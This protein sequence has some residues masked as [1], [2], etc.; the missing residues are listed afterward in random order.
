[1]RILLISY[2]FPP[3][4]IV[5]AVRTGKTAKY[6]WQH[7]HEVRVLTTQRLPF[8]ANL[9]LEI[10]TDAVIRT[11][12]IDTCW[13]SSQVQRMRQQ[14]T[15]VQAVAQHAQTRRMRWLR[16]MMIAYR[17]F[18]AFPDE[19]IGWY[20]FALAAAQRL[21]Q[22]W[23][24]DILL[25]S[26]APPTTLLLAHAL[27]R[28][29]GVPWV[30]EMRDLW[31]D[32][33]YYP[34]PLWRKALDAWLER[35]VLHS[36]AGLVT[37]STP[38]AQT[39]EWRTGKPVGVV[40]NGFDP[41]DYPLQRLPA[42]DGILHIVYTGV[43]YPGHQSAT[44]LFAAL[45]RLGERAGQ[46]RVSFYGNGA[47]Y[48][49]AEAQNQGVERLV[50][51]HGPVPYTDALAQQ[52]AADVVLLLLWNDP[53]EHGVYTGKLFEYLGAR[54]PILAIGPADNVAAALI[55]ERQA[56]IVSSDPAEI[57]AQLTRWLDMKASGADIPDL[58]VS[59]AAGL[60]REEQTRR[61]EQFLERFVGVTSV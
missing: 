48:A 39:L 34:F 3:Y 56:G 55:R 50:V 58:P 21:W 19:A 25:A 59:V 29:Y 18:C 49:L 51:C 30:G 6:L 7:G 36:A 14:A 17:T 60:S 27:H 11:R 8:A 5:A 41:G 53:R 15:F 42:T 38:L 1:M 61:L 23:Q 22:H 28:R 57:A 31:T 13:L 32:N 35:R 2:Y 9:P 46:V 54:R 47:G 24:P 33:H 44:P 12:R 4:N 10:P 37:V 40:L 45:R 16:Q 43:V 20:P 52:R 26:S